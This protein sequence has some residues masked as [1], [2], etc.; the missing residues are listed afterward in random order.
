MCDL[1]MIKA[2]HLISVHACIVMLVIMIKSALKSK[3]GKDCNTHVLFN[4]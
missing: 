1:G 3:Y 4:R 2:S